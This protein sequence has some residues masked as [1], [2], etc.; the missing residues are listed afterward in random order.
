M[1]GSLRLAP[2]MC[3]PSCMGGLGCHAQSGYV[4]NFAAARISI[5]FHSGMKVQYT[6]PYLIMQ[7]HNKWLEVEYQHFMISMSFASSENS[8]SFKTSVSVCQVTGCLPLPTSH[9]CKISIAIFFPLSLCLLAIS[10]ILDPLSSSRSRTPKSVYSD[11]ICAGMLIHLSSQ[12]NL[13]SSRS[14]GRIT[15]I[16]SQ[17]SL[18]PI[19]ERLLAN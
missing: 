17:K 1:W 9:S 15:E 10:R 16:K 13:S 14:V 12:G 19:E 3:P 4:P 8:A 5:V 18:L 7:V 11:P 2:I 6:M